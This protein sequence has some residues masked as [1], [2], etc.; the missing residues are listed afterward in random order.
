MWTVL[1]MALI[2]QNNRGKKLLPWKT[3]QLAVNNSS[4][5]TT[6][7]IWLQYILTVLKSNLR[8][9]EMLGTAVIISRWADLTPKINTIPTNRSPKTMPTPKDHY[10]EIL[11]QIRRCAIIHYKTLRAKKWILWIKIQIQNQ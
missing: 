5:W 8:W 10:S 4:L 7:L 1:G 9:K 11:N 2:S 6:T 3:K